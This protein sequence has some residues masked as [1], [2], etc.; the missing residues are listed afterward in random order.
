[1][2]IVPP[3]MPLLLLL[4]LCLLISRGDAL[5]NRTAHPRNCRGQA[6][7]YGLADDDVTNVQFA[8]LRQRGEVS[9]CFEIEAVARMNFETGLRRKLS[10][11]LQSPQ[12]ILGRR[13]IAGKPRFAI[14]AGMQ[15]D[16]GRRD[17]DGSIDLT[18]FGIDEK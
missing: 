2:I 7:E 5:G 16:D 15:F 12:F 10:G 3:A 14:F 11:S 9:G 6:Y 4:L 8:N 1:M 18:W 13:A 17:P